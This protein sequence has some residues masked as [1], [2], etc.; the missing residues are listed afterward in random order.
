MKIVDAVYQLYRLVTKHIGADGD[1]HSIVDDYAN[2]FLDKEDYKKFKNA[3]G[4]LTVGPDGRELDKLE[5]GSYE[6]MFLD[7]PDPSSFS[8]AKV[9]E[10]GDSGRR[11]VFVQRYWDGALFLKQRSHGA[12]G[13]GP[14]EYGQIERRFLIYKFDGVDVPVGA[15][16]T[17]SIDVSKFKYLEIHMYDRNY[18]YVSTRTNAVQDKYKINKM[19]VSSYY[20]PTYYEI[21]LAKISNTQFKLEKRTRMVPTADGTLTETNAPGANPYIWEIYGI[22]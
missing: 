10:S 18:G 9:L 22:V 4:K 3:Q 2:G 11:I 5:G 19:D 20:K 21:M 8:Y 7:S 6:G 16:L 17:L 12:G 13:S 1:A 14:R 15:N